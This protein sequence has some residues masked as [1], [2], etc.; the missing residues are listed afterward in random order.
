[1]TKKPFLITAAMALLLTLSSAW[2][3]R[4][5]MESEPNDTPAD[6]MRL[7]GEALIMGAIENKD[8]DAYLWTVSDVD[9]LKRWTFELHGIPGRLTIVEIVRLGYA[10]NGVDVTGY[11]KLM[12]MGTRDG[13]KPS[14]QEELIFEPGEYLLGVA[15]AGGGG[16][17]FRPPSVSLS[18]GEESGAEDDEGAE[19]GGYRLLITE[20]R[21]LPI[22]SSQ[23]KPRETRES[24]HS[25]RLGSEF[26]ALTYE[27]SSWYRFDFD[28]KAALQRWE[29]SAQVPLGRDIKAIL[30]NEA[31]ET[32]TSATADGQG[33]LWFKDLA[34]PAGSWWVELQKKG[35]DGY[36]QA[37]G[38]TQTGQ[39]VAGEEAEPNDEWRYANVVDFSQP[40]TG[41]FGKKGE[42]DYFRFSLN[43]ADANQV[44]AVQLENSSE[45]KLQICLLDSHHASLQCRKGKGTLT[46]PDLVLSAG[47]WGLL[48]SRGTEGTEYKISLAAQGAINPD[49]EAEPNDAANL[50]SSV[51]AKNR[52]KGRFT[53]DDTDYFRFVI[54]EEPQLYRF[55][56]MGD[57]IQ[58]VAFL[59]SALSQAQRIRPKSAQKRVRLDNVYLLPGRL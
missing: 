5:V 19:A 12:K 27:P 4:A 47:D 17:A 29:I 51:P 37:I 59:D 44:L 6:A 9:A 50:A 41:R 34:P 35:E 42:S 36:I 55:Q 20:G 3:Q 40:L 30:T 54:A 24:A 2:A 11:E 58:E 16:G 22:K 33:R 1:V 7:G 52:I 28:E 49:T 38:S 48:V 57:G 31:G 32:L 15:A 45:S 21:R 53:G 39:R 23:P 18:F 43:E 13:L 8:Q 56:V 46:L 14:V 25:A 10:E 26:A